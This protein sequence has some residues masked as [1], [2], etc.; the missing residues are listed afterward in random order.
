MRNLT[1]RIPTHVFFCFFIY[2]AS[3]NSGHT[4]IFTFGQTSLRK[5]RT[6]LS[7]QLWVH[8]RRSIVAKDANPFISSAMGSLSDKHRCERC[9]A[10]YLLSYGFSFGQTSLRKMRSFLS[11]QLWVH[12]RTNI[13]AKVAKPF[14]SSALGS[15]SDKHHCERCEAFYLLSYGFTFGQ[16]SLRKMRSFLCPQL[17]VHFR[18]NIIVKDVNPLISSAMGSLS[19]K[20]RCE[21]CEAFYL[22]S[23]GF[24]FGQTSLRKLRSLLSPQLW[25][26]FRT[27]II[28]KVAKPFISSA[29]G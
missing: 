14:I 10:F 25:V 3:S 9:E 27:N 23:Y 11:P 22:L 24:T 28:A 1:T 4:N 18:T 19:E 2:L 17:W 29:M 20:H 16:T 15:L 12:F 5:M 8:F 26:H 13:I 21:R 6:L 7:P